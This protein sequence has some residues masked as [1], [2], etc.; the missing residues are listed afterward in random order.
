MVNK[1]TYDV[2][3]IG[4]GVIGAAISRELS[5][6]QLKTITIEKNKKV[7]METSAG[8]SGVIHGGFDPTPGKLTAKLN[9]EGHKLYQTIFKELNIP[10]QQVNSLVIAFTVEEQA[11]LQMLYERGMTNHINPKDLRIIEQAEVRALEPNI[12][13]EVLSALLCTSSWVV[14][15]VI[16]TKS[17]FQIALKIIKN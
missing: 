2:C 15:P 12:S 3:I 4:G 11:H 9:I 1:P 6:Y 10:H 14:D 13:N 8:N 5:R 17:F 16:L 7:A